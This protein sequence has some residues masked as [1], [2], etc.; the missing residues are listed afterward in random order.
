M[1][2]ISPGKMVNYKVQIN[3]LWDINTLEIFLSRREFRG[4]EI[5]D[6]DRDRKIGR[7]I[8]IKSSNPSISKIS[9][10]ERSV[11]NFVRYTILS[12]EQQKSF[13]KSEYTG[14]YLHDNI[15]DDSD[16]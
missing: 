16:G 9:F 1:L 8:D 12:S 6:I 11:E 7:D 4:K 15:Q 5:S 14:E 10:Y 13:E 3:F 2:I